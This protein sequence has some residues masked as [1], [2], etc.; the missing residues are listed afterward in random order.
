MENNRFWSDNGFADFGK[1][2]QESLAA[3]I[4]KD[5]SFASQISEVLDL[6]YFEVK[7]LRLFVQEIFEFKTKFK[8]FPNNETLGILLGTKFKDQNDPLNKQILDFYNRLQ[9]KTENTVNAEYVKNNALEFCRKQKLKEALVKSVD[10]IKSSSFD[11]I[12][13]VINNA[14]KLG[15]NQDFGHQ[16]IEHFEDRYSLIARNP[17]STGWEMLDKFIKGGLAER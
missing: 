17:I 8:T 15:G 13:S 3:I 5:Q 14:L 4:V 1:P 11:E 7:Y 9:V 6:N 2:F 16:Y 10:L 12:R